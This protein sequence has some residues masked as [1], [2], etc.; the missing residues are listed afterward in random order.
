M[1]AARR[2]VLLLG[3][4]RA[5]PGQ[6]GGPLPAAAF[7]NFLGG[8]DSSSF[9]RSFHVSA[10]SALDDRSRG[11][12]GGGGDDGGELAHLRAVAAAKRL[13]Q[14]VPRRSSSPTPTASALASVLIKLKNRGVIAV[15]PPPHDGAGPSVLSVLR[16]IFWPDADEGGGEASG[17]GAG[18]GHR[19]GHASARGT[20]ASAGESAIP[21][22]GSSGRGESSDGGGGG[23]GSGGAPAP[24][25]PRLGSM[26][27]SFARPEASSLL[28]AGGL[29]AGSAAI[30]LAFPA[31][32]GR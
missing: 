3:Q 5:P 27:F 31:I 20:P 9:W 8:R 28:L 19:H 23:D 24:A 32:M 15:A 1:R 11:E 13:H 22:A 30:S 16:G 7:R 29:V 18:G 6:V 26:L 21:S 12:A 2:A 25:P 17:R 10:P 14:R 4:L